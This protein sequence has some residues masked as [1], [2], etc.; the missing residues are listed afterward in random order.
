[1][2]FE[3]ALQK[4]GFRKEEWSRIQMPIGLT[5]GA[6]SVEEIAVS[7]VAQLIQW[8]RQGDGALGT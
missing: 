2:Q 6:E 1:V 3:A 8:R 4:E 7:I 5:I